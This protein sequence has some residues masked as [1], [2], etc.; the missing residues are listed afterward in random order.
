MLCMVGYAILGRAVMKITTHIDKTL[1]Q[2]ALRATGAKSQRE[3]IEDA[4]RNLLS[5]IQRKRFVKEFD[6]FRLD[7]SVRSLQRQRA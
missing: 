7:L 5:D 6:S 1:L 3:V 2:K 4:L